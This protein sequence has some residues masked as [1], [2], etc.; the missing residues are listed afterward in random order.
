M[1]M[2]KVIFYIF[3]MHLIS[4]KMLFFG[5]LSILLVTIS[6]KKMPKDAASIAIGDTSNYCYDT[7]QKV[8]ANEPRDFGIY[9]IL[10]NYINFYFIVFYIIISDIHI[11]KFFK[12]L[13][14]KIKIMHSHQQ[15]LFILI[16]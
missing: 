11:Y 2:C 10:L 1:S 3:I 12:K 5:I 7:V 13:H 15:L 14:D 16:Y 6:A 8:C 9:F 4:A